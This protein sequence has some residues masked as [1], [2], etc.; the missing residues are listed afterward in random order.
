MKKHIILQ[1]KTSILDKSLLLL[2]PQQLGYKTL[3]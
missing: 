3:L 2:F 1:V